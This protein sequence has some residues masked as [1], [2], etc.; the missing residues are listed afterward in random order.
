M[1]PARSFALPH[2]SPVH[3][4]LSIFLR[5]FLLVAGLVAAGVVAVVFCLLV[6]A[7]LLRAAWARLTGRP[8]APFG[9]RFGPRAAFDEMM[10]RAPPAAASRTPRADAATGRRAP[11]PAVTDVEPK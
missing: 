10:R 11:T 6:T 3:F 2:N 1:A 4:F 7:W 8:L 9:M 5:L